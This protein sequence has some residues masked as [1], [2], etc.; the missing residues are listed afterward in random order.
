MHLT[1]SARLELLGIQIKAAP[2]E[3]GCGCNS[4]GEPGESD[5]LENQFEEVAVIAKQLEQAELREME[6]TL[7]RHQTLLANLEVSELFRKFQA[8]PSFDPRPTWREC[9]LVDRLQSSEGARSGIPAEERP[10]VRWFAPDGVK[11][12]SYRPHTN[13]IY[14]QIGLGEEQ[15]IHVW[16][17]EYEH[18]KIH[19]RGFEQSEAICELAGEWL[20]QRVHDGMV[21]GVKV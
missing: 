10:R 7:K 9:Y 1:N 12:G 16:G 13:E 14:L 2:T 8:D 6:A 19:R 18:M 20:L 3:C 5:T 17:H 4:C 21:D 15:L 11:W